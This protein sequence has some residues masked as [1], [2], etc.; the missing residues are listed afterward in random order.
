[1]QKFRKV[2]KII[3]RGRKLDFE[4]VFIFQAGKLCPCDWRDRATGHVYVE[5]GLKKIS[6]WKVSVSKQGLTVM[7]RDIYL[8]ISPS[9]HNTKSGVE[10]NPIGYFSH[11]P[12]YTYKEYFHLRSSAPKTINPSFYQ[13]LPFHH[14][15]YW[16]MWVSKTEQCSLRN[17]WDSLELA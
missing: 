3:S 6:R 17:S 2:A 8:W 14:L 11:H 4:E 12:F 7:E 15:K 5:H 16:L 13:P 10:F 1:M 9:K